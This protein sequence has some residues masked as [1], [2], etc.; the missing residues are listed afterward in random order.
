[1]IEEASK[2]PKGRGAGGTGEPR[3]FSDTVDDSVV[4]NQSHPT[5]HNEEAS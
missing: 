5:R 4:L 3:T 1:M 2:R